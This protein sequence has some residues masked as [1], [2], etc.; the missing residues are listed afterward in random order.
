MLGGPCLQ[1]SKAFRDKTLCIAAQVPCP[2][3][4]DLG[5]LVQRIDRLMQLAT[6]HAWSRQDALAA[7]AEQSLLQAVS[8]AEEG[9]EAAAPDNAWPASEMTI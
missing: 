6:S 4:L 1:L 8:S 3:A 5:A 7:A 9:E 2:T